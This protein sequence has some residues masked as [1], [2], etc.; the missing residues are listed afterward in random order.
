MLMVEGLSDAEIGERLVIGPSTVEFHI[1]NI[2][3]KPGISGRAEA[4]ALA[5]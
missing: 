1:N 4:V 3:F 5:Q 2:L